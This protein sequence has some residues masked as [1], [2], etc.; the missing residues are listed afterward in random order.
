VFRQLIVND[1]RNGPKSS[2][3]QASRA[4]DRL[5]ELLNVLRSSTPTVWLAIRYQP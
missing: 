3:P 4:I 2:A 5:I 1:T